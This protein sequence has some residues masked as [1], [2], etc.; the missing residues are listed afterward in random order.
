MP[1]FLERWAAHGNSDPPESVDRRAT[2]QRRG[3]CKLGELCIRT[4]RR[5]RQSSM[6]RIRADNGLHERPHPGKSG[7]LLESCQKAPRERGFLPQAL[8]DPSGPPPL[9]PPPPQP[10][11][12]IPKIPLP[13]RDTVKGIPA[14]TG[15][16]SRR[17]PPRPPNDSGIL[18]GRQ[19]FPGR[20]PARE[21]NRF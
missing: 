6:S 15:T 10:V 17:P 16:D 20:T 8:S 12:I 13:E 21:A 2:L 11:L 9:C 4:L 7:K 18:Q 14:T 5:N 19:V 3:F 1:M